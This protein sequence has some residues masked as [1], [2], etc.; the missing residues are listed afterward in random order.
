MTL[1]ELHARTRS[2]HAGDASPAID[3]DDRS[4][5]VPEVGGGE[6][7]AWRPSPRSPASPSGARQGGGGRQGGLDGQGGE[8]ASRA[9]GGRPLISL[10]AHQCTSYA[11]E[12]NSDAGSGSNE[13]VCSGDLSTDSD[14][15]GLVFDAAVYKVQAEAARKRAEA[16]AAAKAGAGAIHID[17]DAA[18]RKLMLQPAGQAFREREAL[19]KVNR[20]LEDT[21]IQNPVTRPP[22]KLESL[23]RYRRQLAEP[24]IMKTDIVE[25]RQ[26]LRHAYRSMPHLD[27]FS[28]VSFLLRGLQSI[29]RSANGG[30]TFWHEDD[31]SFK[32]EMGPKE[33]NRYTRQLLLAM[34]FVK[35]S[36]YWVWP[37]VH[38]AE[39]R[40]SVSWGDAEVPEDCPGRDPSRLDDMILVLQCCKSCLRKSGA[41]FTGFFP[42]QC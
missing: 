11:A 34:G 38:L 32:H 3:F 16:Q 23:N 30:P 19:E 41:A 39:A 6:L 14:S 20:A 27:F 10:G 31:P 26:R 5:A 1:D 22:R 40:Q 33:A 24:H 13:S 42:I 37:H 25:V 9:P 36:C 21:T 18:L 17:S 28:L 8:S 2:H 12:A 29:R 4:P 35:L 15:E 7:Q